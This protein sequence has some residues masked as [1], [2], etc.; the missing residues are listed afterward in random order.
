[1]YSTFIIY[2]QRRGTSCLKI[3]LCTHN[4]RTALSRDAGLQW[5]PTCDFLTFQSLVRKL[6]NL[7]SVTY[8]RVNENFVRDVDELR[9]RFNDDDP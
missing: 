7:G 2:N 4:R 3:T 5:H 8:E 9:R 1:M 6:H